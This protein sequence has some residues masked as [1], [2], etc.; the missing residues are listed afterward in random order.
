MASLHRRILNWLDERFGAGKVE[1]FLRHKTVPVGR[2]DPG[3]AV[4][5]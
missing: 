5:C 2:L 3:D 4:E 1:D